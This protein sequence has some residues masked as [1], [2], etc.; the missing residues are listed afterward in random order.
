MPSAQLQIIIGDVHGCLSELQA[1]WQQLPLAQAEKIVFLGDLIDKGPDSDGVLDFVWSQQQRW[2]LVLIRG[3]HE[4]K[5]LRNLRRERPLEFRP[6]P[7]RLALLQS[8]QPFY[9]FHQGRGLAVHGGIYPGFWKHEPELPNLATEAQWSRKLTNQ[10]QRFAFCRY[11]NPAGHTVALGTETAADSFW[12]S[13]YD[14]RAGTVFFGHEPF[15]DGVAHFEHAHGLD[16]GCVF[17]GQLTAALVSAQGQL[18]WVQQPAEQRYA[19]P[20]VFGL[21]SASNEMEPDI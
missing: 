19:E 15:L 21:R 14:G 17:G 16:T 5:A 4:A 7:E 2:P 10:V 3:N 8:M 11:V 13:R 9:R 20:L 6:T 1:L 12:A 18:D